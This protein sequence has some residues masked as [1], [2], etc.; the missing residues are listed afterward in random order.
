MLPAR[1]PPPVATG[2]M[3][4]CRAM[5]TA[6][7]DRR[8]ARS[9][10]G[11]RRAAGARSPRPQRLVAHGPEIVLGIAIVGWALVF[12]VLVYLKHDRFASVDFDMGIHDQSVWLLAH[13]RGFMTVR[14]LQVFGH[15]ATPGYYLF[16]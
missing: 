4:P 11:A 10:P 13:L 12:S 6:T 5:G 1:R 16:V 14:G 7:G 15:H 2:P 9:E 3:R 8:L